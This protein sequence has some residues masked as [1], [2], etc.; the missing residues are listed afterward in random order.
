MLKNLKSVYFI[1]K[2]FSYLEEYKKL[3]LIKYNKSTQKNINISLINYKL[4][5]GNYIIY[6][7]QK[8]GKEYNCEHKLIYEGEY[9]NGERNGKGKEYDDNGKLIFEGEF[10]NGQAIKYYDYNDLMDD[11]LKLHK[12]SKIYDSNNN[13]INSLN[14]KS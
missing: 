3:K 11:F 6:E 5:N 12:V 13:K 2:I 4:L 10:V 8:R 9:L 7:N 1:R 14:N